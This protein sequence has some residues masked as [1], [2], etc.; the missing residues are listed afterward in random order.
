PG[1]YGRSPRPLCPTLQAVQSPPLTEMQLSG[2]AAAA[3]AGTASPGDTA[4]A[5][6]A[7]IPALIN[8]RRA[9]IDNIPISSLIVRRRARRR[10]DRL[11][12]AVPAVRARCP[13][14]FGRK[15]QA[16]RTSAVGLR[17]S[18]RFQIGLD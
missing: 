17:S 16:W 6:P 8:A 14:G 11:G 2:V 15:R 4:T 12:G 7:P 3:D 13:G 10:G 5:R 9:F 1:R 18:P